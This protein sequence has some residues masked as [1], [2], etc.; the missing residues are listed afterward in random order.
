LAAAFFLVIMVLL[1]AT[2][3]YLL[4]WTENYYTG[5]ISS[6]LRRESL[7]I[8]RLVESSPQDVP[9]VIIR[10][11]RDLGHRVTIIRADGRVLADSDSDYRKMP[12]H[13]DRPEFRQAM[14]AGYGTS[15]RYSKT[16]KTRMLYVATSYGTKKISYGVVRVAEPLSGLDELMSAIQRTFLF[17][18]LVAILAAAVISLKLAS[19]ITGP[20]ESI[21]SAAR[22]L[23]R[24]D[25]GARALARGKTAGEI[26]ELA[27]AFN[28]MA[29][30][31]QNNMDEINRQS[32][33]MRAIFDH[34]DNGLILAD[35]Q[36]RIEMINPAACR[37]L[38]V[39]T[40]GS[41]RKTLIET[42]LSH[43]L[44]SL[45]ERVRRTQEPAALDIDI[46][47]KEKRF[48][49]AYV[50]PVPMAESGVD[51]LIVLHDVTSLRNTD[52]IRRDFVANVS[53]ELRTPLATIKAIAE[54]I[55]LRH[56]GN[57]AAMPGFAESI[58]QEA[59]R[60]TLLAEDL[61]DLTRIETRPVDVAVERI[62]L[63]K[64]VSDIL[65]RLSGAA[66]KKNV[67][68]ES[69][70][71][72]DEVIETDSG[73]L[74]QILA[75]LVDN[76][77]K[78]TPDG[79]SVRVYLERRPNGIAIKVTDNGIGIPEEDQPRIFERF[80]RVDKDRSRQSGGTGLGLAIVKHLCEQIGGS[81]AVKSA[82]GA[83][84]TFSVLLPICIHSGESAT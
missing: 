65:D 78:Y 17:A 5:S 28:S 13:S 67:T 33:R 63:Y 43:D 11:G 50:T 45:V 6:D 7:A 71:K 74:T 21:A 8:T 53:H 34:T 23:E 20:I 41:I 26:S 24:G 42:T 70:I 15:A 64:L 25:L 59:D 75:N 39:D 16:L 55:L 60:M 32:V 83:G 84:S 36:G 57:P 12:N 73:S 58:V 3:L 18:G 44:A 72:Q 47:A 10:M 76:A 80:Y 1:S 22:R 79:G 4:D 61:L 30:Q 81:V 40:P 69:E 51:M 54:T 19:S 29:E 14:A 27:S 49:Y 82:P 37:I 2:G 31:L 52:A 56:E 38:S 9:D 68:L 35:P 66:G 62:N 46:S 48:V 77:I